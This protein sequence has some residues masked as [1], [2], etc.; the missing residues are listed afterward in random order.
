VGVGVVVMLSA[1]LVLLR[2]NQKDEAPRQ[3]HVSS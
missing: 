2:I 3:D 1:S